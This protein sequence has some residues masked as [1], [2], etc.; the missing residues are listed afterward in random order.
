MPPTSILKIKKYIQSERERGFDNRTIIGG[1]D[2][3]IST[4][5][6]DAHLDKIHEDQIR[7]VAD[8]F[9]SYPDQSV[10]DRKVGLDKIWNEFHLSDFAPHIS[11]APRKQNPSH[12]NRPLETR[13]VTSSPAAINKPITST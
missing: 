4:W 10:N 6:S 2:K 11:H 1:L 5:A 9:K 7:L 8:L 3:V 12:Q 13:A